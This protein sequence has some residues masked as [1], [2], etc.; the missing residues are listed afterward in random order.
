MCT[1]AAW[2]MKFE[3]GNSP[4]PKH[5]KLCVAHSLYYSVW[6]GYGWDGTSSK[7]GLI[8][9]KRQEHACL[10][11][12]GCVDCAPQMEQRFGPAPHRG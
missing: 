6:R 7:L 4:M 9:S 11:T 8:G 2:V 3:H 12:S 10:E 5:L 1:H